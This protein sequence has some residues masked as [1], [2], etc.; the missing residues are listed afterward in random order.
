[1][2]SS[3]PVAP[4]RAFC[5]MIHCF[6]RAPSMFMTDTR[7][8]FYVL[9]P[10]GLGSRHHQ[11][12]SKT[13]LTPDSGALAPDARGRGS[14]HEYRV[15][16]SVPRTERRAYGMARGAKATT[17]V[18]MSSPRSRTSGLVSSPSD[19]EGGGGGNTG[20]PAGHG[21]AGSRGGSING[22]AG[23]GCRAGT[24]TS[25]ISSDG[26]SSRYAHA[27]ADARSF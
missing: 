24:S 19:G 13:D 15:G 27:T 18:H 8:A 14:A 9:P 3:P 11:N 21:A 4:Q 12:V 10:R 2:H 23:K 7:H 22:T 6:M 25:E 20:I 16:V 26:R 5:I 1:M 17:D